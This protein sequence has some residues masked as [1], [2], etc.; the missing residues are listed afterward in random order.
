ML[1]LDPITCNVNGT[2]FSLDTY[3]ELLVKSRPVNALCLPPIW[4][5]ILDRYEIVSKLGEGSYGQV[6]RATC[7]TRGTSVAIKLVENFEQ[8]DHACIKI[9]REI[10]L[11]RRLN[12]LQQASG[13]TY[14]PELL[15]IIIPKQAGMS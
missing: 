12:E 4:Q 6:F 3:I 1:S 10:Q 14:F 8:N 7:R 5:T 9:I 2:Q 11:M 13:F 15:D